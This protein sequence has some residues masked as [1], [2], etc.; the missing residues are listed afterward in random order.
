MASNKVLQNLISHASFYFLN[1]ATR[2]LKLHV[3]HILFLLDSPDLEEEI[4]GG[5]GFY[6]L[7]SFHMVVVLGGYMLLNWIWWRWGIDCQ[8]MMFEEGT[9]EFFVLRKFHL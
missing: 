3:A 6:R 4:R 8:P 5:Q 1:V 2:N 9:F 7:F